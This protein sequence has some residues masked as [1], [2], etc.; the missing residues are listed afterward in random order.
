MYFLA[1]PLIL[2]IMVMMLKKIKTMGIKGRLRKL[3]GENISQV[4]ELYTP[5]EIVNMWID[6]IFQGNI[7]KW[8]RAITPNM[9]L[10]QTLQTKKASE[11]VFPSDTITEFG[12][13][14]DEEIDKWCHKLY[15]ICKES[16]EANGSINFCFF[17][18]DNLPRIDKFV[19]RVKLVIGEANQTEGS[20]LLFILRQSVSNSQ[21]LI[22][23]FQAMEPILQEKFFP[24]DANWKTTC[25]YFRSLKTLVKILDHKAEYS[26]HED[27]RISPF[28]EIFDGLRKC[29]YAIS[30]RRPIL[31][32]LEHI[33]NCDPLTLDFLCDFT[34]H[35][36]NKKIC[37]LVSYDRKN[38]PKMPKLKQIILALQQQNCWKTPEE[39]IDQYLIPNHLI[40]KSNE[41][42]TLNYYLNNC[43]STPK[44]QL[45]GINGDM[46]IGKTF[47]ANTFLEKYSK[48]ERIWTLSYSYTRSCLEDPYILH[49]LARIMEHF[50][51]EKD[52]FDQATCDRISQL[53]EFLGCNFPET[54]AKL[55]G[56]IK[57]ADSN[58][59]EKLNNF[60]KHGMSDH[61]VIMEKQ[62]RLWQ[63]V[64]EVIG[65]ISSSRPIIIFLDDFH[66]ADNAMLTF[67]S[68]LS[69]LSVN[70][71]IFIIFT[72]NERMPHQKSHSF[73]NFIE[74]IKN[75]ENFIEL[76]LSP[77][78]PDDIVQYIS[79]SFN[80]NLFAETAT[81]PFVQKL[82]RMT[83]GNTF[84]LTE[85]LKYLVNQ[86]SLYPFGGFWILKEDI[87]DTY[88]TSEM[89][90]QNLTNTLSVDERD[91]L[92]PTL[93]DGALCGQSFPL[94]FAENIFS[95]ASYSWDDV[96]RI[97]N[98][99]ISRNI[100]LRKD[101]RQGYI[102]FT[103]AQYRQNILDGIIGKNKKETYQKLLS[104]YINSPEKSTNKLYYYSHQSNEWQGVIEFSEIVGSHTLNLF[105]LQTAREIF[106]TGIDA[107]KAIYD[108]AVLAKYYLL[109]SETYP[110]QKY[111]PKVEDFELLLKKE[112]FESA[113]NIANNI[114]NP[115]EACELLTRAVEQMNPKKKDIVSLILEKVMYLIDSIESEHVRIYFLKKSISFFQEADPIKLRSLVEVT[116]PLIEGIYNHK[117][118]ADIYLTLERELDEMDLDL[119]QEISHM[120]SPKYSYAE[121]AISINYI[122][123]FL[124]KNIS[125]VDALIE[126]SEGIYD[127]VF[128]IMS[129][130]AILEK[131]ITINGEKSY[132]LLDK[133]FLALENISAYPKRLQALN[134]FITG[135]VE[136]IEQTNL[137]VML[138]NIPEE[139]QLEVFSKLIDITIPVPDISHKTETLNHLAIII[140]QTLKGE[141]LEELLG[142]IIAEVDKFKDNL[143]KGKILVDIACEVIHGDINLSYQFLEDSIREL[144]NLDMKTIS[145]QEEKLVNILHKSF[146]L[147]NKLPQP[148]SYPMWDSIV[149]IA[150]K[151]RDHNRDKL[152]S[153]IMTVLFPMDQ[154]KAM[155]LALKIKDIKYRFRAMRYLLELPQQVLEVDT[156]E[157]VILEQAI[158]SY[159]S[160]LLQELAQKDLGRARRLLRRLPSSLNTQIA[161]VQLCY[162]P[163][164]RIQEILA[165]I[166][167]DMSYE[168][169]TKIFASI[170][171]LLRKNEYDREG[172]YAILEIIS[173]GYLEKIQLLIWIVIAT[174]EIDPVI[175]CNSFQHIPALIEKHISESEQGETDYHISQMISN[176]EETAQKIKPKFVEN[177][178]GRILPEISII[179]SLNIQAKI[180]KILS[181]KLREVSGD[182]FYKVVENLNPELRFEIL[183][184]V[185][186]DISKSNTIINFKK[187]SELLGES[188]LECFAALGALEQKIPILGQPVRQLLKENVI[189]MRNPQQKLDMWIKI[190][191]ISSG[192]DNQFGNFVLDK[193]LE[194]T[195]KFPRTEMAPYYKLIKVIYALPIPIKHDFITKV[196]EHLTSDENPIVQIDENKTYLAE[197]MQ[198]F[199][200]LMPFGE[201]YVHSF[202]TRLFVL[203]KRNFDFTK[204]MG[205]II[206]LLTLTRGLVPDKQSEWIIE[207]IAYL[208]T[209]EDDTEVELQQD[210]F[211]L[212][213]LSMVSLAQDLIVIQKE[214]AL[215]ASQRALQ[216]TEYSSSRLRL[217]RY[218][219]LK[220]S[221]IID[222]M[223]FEMKEENIE[224]LLPIKILRLN[225]AYYHL[226]NLKDISLDEKK[227]FLKEQKNAFKEMLNYLI[228]YIKGTLP[229]QD[230]NELEEAFLAAHDK[231]K[232]E[233]EETFQKLLVAKSG[234][235]LTQAFF[236]CS[237]ALCMID[238]ESL[239]N[240]PTPWLHRLIRIASRIDPMSL[241]IAG[242][243]ALKVDEWQEFYLLV[244]R[245]SYIFPRSVLILIKSLFSME[246][247]TE[248][249][250]TLEDDDLT[251]GIVKSYLPILENKH[252]RE[253]RDHLI[254][255]MS[256]EWI[257]YGWQDGFLLSSNINNQILQSKTIIRLLRKS[258]DYY[259]REHVSIAER[260]H[261]MLQK[262]KNSQTK[263]LA[264]VELA[265][266]IAEI[267]FAKALDIIFSIE[268][269]NKK[270]EA[271]ERI[272]S[273][274]SI[275][276]ALKF[277]TQIQDSEYITIS[278]RTLMCRLP[279]ESEERIYYLNQIF[280]IILSIEDND[281]RI[282]IM[283]YY[284][285]IG[286]REEDILQK[287][288]VVNRNI[289]EMWES[290]SHTEKKLALELI[291]YTVPVISKTLEQKVIMDLFKNVYSKGDFPAFTSKEYNTIIL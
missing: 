202:I 210:Q 168:D 169:L 187:D 231:L 42:E 258:L 266:K 214:E 50:K 247:I 243:D 34:Q 71:P 100:L 117:A 205:C 98:K 281:L 219:L 291:C 8:K 123:G 150:S 221:T 178:I 229:K 72:W 279:Q 137:G 32:I 130:R 111:L 17:Y 75:C 144:T 176:F 43:F 55:Q 215:R 159:G 188:T 135:K 127:S 19:E 204:W 280:Q 79:K 56:I 173:D 44:L 272:I 145:S 191:S 248:I 237:Q 103:H 106:D 196:I 131:T 9:L 199:V 267:D 33:D 223:H 217:H 92:L 104:Y 24:G 225:C 41:L 46:G 271:F 241:K 179:S 30:L 273:E 48:D 54:R 67:I 87:H 115:G 70:Y 154:E 3:W 230:I 84:F 212:K 88:V 239:E 183:E 189:S 211:L 121:K 86:K 77:L 246:K 113:I 186:G 15:N 216:L 107:A 128:Y 197:I 94:D 5:P 213:A 23:I 249:S 57:T 142:K 163:G 157:E 20:E 139:K 245:V 47:L 74:N 242:D 156:L 124:G 203:P 160:I 149:S 182:M 155:E 252:L 2:P 226:Q 78:K 120:I 285:T 133:I 37:F 235:G 140:P 22:S 177:Y 65:L 14:L 49:P 83:N 256:L 200:N 269:R 18:S 283:K 290:A 69:T 152:F 90:L 255:L 238:D 192:W 6:N 116:L 193:I 66:M 276:K 254:A 76:N 260:A 201:A 125:L 166:N 261:M 147:L 82:I 126:E 97:M 277:I 110:R 138:T 185:S 153:E 95:N 27:I 184:E 208:D 61:E 236:I 227:S 198:I 207:T 209:L 190:L 85:F 218:I 282:E 250:P 259:S 264:T 62:N 28:I 171:N 59:V 26:Q 51:E 257:E 284:I 1:L 287:S 175:A 288:D 29:F 16:F 38:V 101:P 251:I 112:E 222:H 12:I 233:F 268:S 31:I 262:M 119:I 162:P 253:Q 99:L 143:D 13:E 4:A 265:V 275:E 118:Q 45:I 234:V 195:H 10:S 263:T 289:M 151:T 68:Q 39:E 40:G 278:L 58:F 174:Q 108:V 164:Q 11:I 122:S 53:A 136:R 270:V 93:Q 146:P 224:A 63:E 161:N 194:L 165:L 180:I 141:K 35:D 220:L 21:R 73:G 80:P 91:L 132:T 96:Q 109:K 25:S 167:D 102:E 36:R 181:Q 232:I 148:L 170:E 134:A 60:D 158:D 114:E 244:Q 81:S 274:L 7:Q 172:N 105:E 89:L 240:W 286:L 52:Y 64:I 228:S 129:I 206:E